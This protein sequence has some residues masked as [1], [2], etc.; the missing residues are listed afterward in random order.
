M[1]LALIERA[2]ALADSTDWIKTAE[3]M[4]KLQ[5]EWQQIGPVPRPDTRPRGSGS[6]TRA[7]VLHAP[8]RRPGAAQGSLVGEPGEEGSAVRARRGAR[9]RRATGT[10]RP[11]RSAGC[12]RTGRT[13][14]RCAATSPKRCGS[15]SAP[16]ATRSS[17]ATSGATRSSSSRSRRIAKRWSPSSRRCAAPNPR[18]I[19]RRRA[20]LL[21]QVRSLRT[22]WNQSTPVV[23]HGADPL[24]GRFVNAL[25]RLLTSYPDAFRGT[26]L[27][28][29]PSRQ[30][31]EKL[32]RGSKGS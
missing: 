17:I 24:S 5:A 21:E 2:E 12:R 30:R 10:R 26:E 31:M 6:A 25:E 20:G 9:R 8:Q 29:E 13:S 16:P 19:E 22:R 14:A 15:A 3:E 4:K 7:T 23:R 11:P 28:V 27:D 32:V 1:K 18:Q